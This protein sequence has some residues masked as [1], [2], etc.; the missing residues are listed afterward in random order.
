M[1]RSLDDTSPI[2]DGPAGRRGGDPRRL[3]RSAARAMAAAISSLIIATLVVSRSADALDPDG[4]VA[5]NK[6]QVGTV[7]LVD[8]DAGRS[9]VDL[10]AMGPGQPVVQCIRVQYDGTILPVDLSLAATSE[11]DLDDFIDVEAEW[12]QG[13]GFGSCDGFVPEKQLYEGTLA[14]LT[15]REPLPVAGFVNQGDAISFRFRFELQDDERALGKVTS[16][17]FVWEA[18][19]R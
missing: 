14:S 9:L 2:D 19:P 10:E 5:G 8:D 13:G 12:G 17:D 11:G 16:V 4:T 1:A 18:V 15:E 3:D 6:L 7:N